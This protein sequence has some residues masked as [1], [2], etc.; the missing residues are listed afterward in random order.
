MAYMT[1]SSRFTLRHN[2]LDARFISFYPTV[3]ANLQRFQYK[4]VGF[5]LLNSRLI[6]RVWI[7]FDINPCS[8]IFLPLLQ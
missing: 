4:D 2:F 8:A 6:L 3:N 5:N 7:M 1:C